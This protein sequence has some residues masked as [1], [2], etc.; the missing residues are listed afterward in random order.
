MAWH[1]KYCM[2]RHANGI[3][4]VE[5]CGKKSCCVVR[6]SPVDSDC[7]MDAVFAFKDVECTRPGMFGFW[8]VVDEF[9]QQE[10]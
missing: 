7:P 1:F 9:E 5:C 8:N 3:I 2:G 10:E 4:F 6:R